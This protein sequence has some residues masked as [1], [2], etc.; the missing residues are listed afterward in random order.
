MS[1][2]GCVIA[3]QIRQSHEEEIADLQ[4]TMAKQEAII[5]C[6][7]SDLENL[8]NSLSSKTTELADKDHE[9]E[10]IKEEMSALQRSFEASENVVSNQ[11]EVYRSVL[12]MAS[13]CFS[14]CSAKSSCSPGS[15]T[16]VP[17]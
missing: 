7:K 10:R 12:H 16:C 9:I 17:R 2:E 3:A 4:L 1:S 11:N 6:L 8:N 5:E 14:D 15:R 13:V